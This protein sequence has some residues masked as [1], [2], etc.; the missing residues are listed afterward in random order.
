[1]DP[2][3]RL[4]METS[5]E[6]IEDAGLTTQQLAGSDTGVFAGCLTADYWDL[7]RDAGLRDLRAS[8]GAN[9]WGVPAGRV[10]RAFDLH[11]PSLGV[12]ATCATS[13]V[14][15]HLACQS[16]RSGE[17]GVAVVAAADVLLAPDLHVGFSGAGALSPD[18]QCRFGAADA[19]GYVRSD[20]AAAVVLK[21]LRAALADGDRVRAV[22]LASA[23]SHNGSTSTTLI[24]PSAD[25]QER[26]LRGA[27]RVA[28]IDPADV[29]YVEAHGTGT[30]KGDTAELLALDRVL[31]VGRDADRP[32][33]V[34][35]V[36]TNVGHT[37]FVAGLVGLIKTALAM[38][39][40]VIPASLHADDPS[41]LMASLAPRFHLVRSEW[42]WP[43]RDRPRLA[44]ISAFGLS[45]VNAHVVVT[46]A[47]RRF[48]TASTRAHGTEVL[49]LPMSARTPDA[50][51][52][53]A[54]AYRGRLERT[55]EVRVLRDICFS[56]GARRSQ[57]GYRAVAV[58]TRTE[59][60]DQLLD[61]SVE[62]APENVAAKGTDTVGTVGLVFAG[63][64]GEDLA[65]VVDD[66]RRSSPAFHRAFDDCDSVV[67]AELGWS[68]VDSL[69][70]G[71]T[72]SPVVRDV[73]FLSLQLATASLWQHWGVQPDR[74]IGDG[75]G[76]IAAAVISGTLDT[77]DA[78]N[79]ITRR[80]RYTHAQ[81][82][83]DRAPRIHIGA[84]N[85][86]AMLSTLGTLWTAGHPVPW[87]R[88]YP[89][90]SYTPVPHHPWKRRR[91][92]VDTAVDSPS[93]TA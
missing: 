19:N 90:A 40:G 8:V 6:A 58:G 1:M 89:G 12:A 24:A 69:G 74:T 23:V 4:V 30:P 45:G 65:G 56:A 87:P 81:R 57:F 62:R 29:D 88:V 93:I 73:L 35:S 15:V 68:I 44:G 83:P 27:Y 71:P 25:G 79:T 86:A 34:G 22:V 16:L 63:Q 50:V 20:G 14:G 75:I 28:G 78:V 13:L 85:Y 61:P 49:I 17:C 70:A 46:E 53:L 37:E 72:D 52:E 82:L 38:E 60:L 64:A 48:P 77:A 59:L 39:H 51:H 21:P 43:A 67:R 9:S 18:G 66:L 31:G 84:E 32:C 5:W 41:E 55:D 33:L 7:L 11:G 26:A 47:P 54:A 92:W 2:Q 80:R 36:K 91:Y 3:H 42:P 10:S 76:A